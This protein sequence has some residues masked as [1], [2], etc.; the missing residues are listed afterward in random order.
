MA[1]GESLGPVAYHLDISTTSHRPRHDNGP[2]PVARAHDQLLVGEHGSDLKIEAEPGYA[3][4]PSRGIAR[5]APRA[6]PCV[7]GLERH[8]VEAQG[9]RAP[10]GVHDG[11]GAE[12]IRAAVLAAQP[13]E[14]EIAPV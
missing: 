9:P 13:V 12:A 6:R 5:A 3:E 8:L 14:H 2:L 4:P 7:D 1:F 10:R 11:A